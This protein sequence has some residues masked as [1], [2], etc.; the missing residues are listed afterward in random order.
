MKK[1]LLNESEI[2]KMMKFAN[3][4]PLTTPF[5][6]RLEEGGYGG[7]P[8]YQKDDEEEEADMIDD[9]AAGPAGDVPGDPGEAPMDMG[10]DAEEP[11]ADDLP[12][13]ELGGEEGGEEVT[14]NLTAE[15]ADIIAPVLEDLATQVREMAGDG[16]D[17]G[18]DTDAF[19]D[20]ETDEQPLPEPDGLD[21]DSMDMEDEEELEEGA[22][23]PKAGEEDERSERLLFK[24]ASFEHTLTA[25]LVSDLESQLVLANKRLFACEKF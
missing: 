13:P 12:S 23:S 25:K 17:D 16:M 3:L 24:R 7:M 4:Q 15:Q 9:P 14:W 1:E 11:E 8:A 19:S 22:S 2:R 18:E 20:S 10:L 21:P 6:E 5:I